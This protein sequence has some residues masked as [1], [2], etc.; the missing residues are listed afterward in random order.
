MVKRK[1][2]GNLHGQGMG[3]HSKTEI[4]QLGIR[5]IDAIAA[6]LGEKPWLMGANPCG[7]DASVWSAVSGL[8][9][10]LFDTPLYAAAT[11]HANLVAYRD[12][13]LK[14]WFPDFNATAT[15]GG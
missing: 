14:A 12:R 6:F 2:K 10:P 8:M 3:R 5:D 15:E 1:V 9:T 7:A 4:E 11:R 13:G